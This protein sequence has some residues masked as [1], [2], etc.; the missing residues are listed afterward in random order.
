MQELFSLIGWS[1]Q[2]QSG[3]ADSII[4][5]NKAVA[6]AEAAQART[7][8]LLKNAVSEQQQMTA[9]AEKESQ[10]RN[11]LEA[12]EKLRT[13]ATTSYNTIGADGQRQ[14]GDAS[15][16]AKISEIDLKER[17]ITGEIV[18]NEADI[19]KLKDQQRE[20]AEAAASAEVKYQNALAERAA[21]E[22]QLQMVAE[23]QGKPNQKVLEIAADRVGLEAQLASAQREQTDAESRQVASGK[24]L[25][26][27]QERLAGLWGER[28]FVTGPAQEGIDNQIELTERRIEDVSQRRKGLLTEIQGI[29]NN[30]I[31]TRK[32]ITKSAQDEKAATHELAVT[33]RSRQAESSQ[34]TLNSV[35]NE[36][37]V[38][39]QTP[40]SVQQHKRLLTL[41]DQER[42]TIKQ[43]IADQE[44]WIKSGGLKPDE[45]AQAEA[46]LARLKMESQQVD[47]GIT[48]ATKPKSQKIS[49]DYAALDDS[50][51]HIQTMGEAWKAGVEGWMTSLGTSAERVAG[52]M[53]T[54]L[55][56]VVNGVTDGI[57]GWIT[58]SKS[59]GQAMLQTWGTIRRAAIQTV[60][61]WLT[62]QAMAEGMTVLYHAASK[63]KMFGID[64]AYAAKGLAIQAAQAAKSLI[65]WLPSAIASSISSFGV[66]AALGVAAVVAAIAAASG[67]FYDGGMT[68][69]GPDR[70]VK[71]VVHEEEWVGPK[72]MVRS[73]VFGPIIRSL[74]GAR[75]RG[76][77]DG[78]FVNL[79]P[80][81]GLADTITRS[82][83]DAH[84]QAASG[85]S[86]SQG[87][88]AAGSPINLAIVDSDT[89]ASRYA[90]SRRGRT[91]IISAD[92]QRRTTMRLRN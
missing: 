28:A 60:V 51:M 1:D 27:L 89:A 29:L 81:L 59:F 45:L 13:D 43:M 34:A 68:G 67:G 4:E 53:Q 38:V 2:L 66:S 20:R 35:R 48:Q 24:E 57:D 85:S 18:S 31:G 84:E 75:Q 9:L 79:D 72:W 88:S 91:A 64:V 55:G 61:E 33:T 65:M 87:A 47:L 11:H 15:Y 52:L 39:E 50:T 3:L 14:I 70:T 32:Q 5:R 36:R 58:G 54:S 62:K 71:G 7:N 10:L 30:I 26:G 6:E 90:S 86:A 25:I 83:V 21:L 77:Y 40:F 37:Q 56:S 44:A 73:P 23:A 92:R 12:Q 74:E 80:S 63:A 46:T 49:E 17:E 82:G 41:L 16:S 69:S 22:K 42:A 76:Y 8:A 78:G 19:F